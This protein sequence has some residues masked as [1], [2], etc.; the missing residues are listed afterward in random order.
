MV[1]KA[2]IGSNQ[3]QFTYSEIQKINNFERILDL[4]GFGI[5]Y[6]GSIGETQV[7]VKI[8][9]PSSVQGPQEFHAEARLSL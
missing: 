7:A 4:G 6:H 3:R 8:L 2:T 9:S 1:V 5:V